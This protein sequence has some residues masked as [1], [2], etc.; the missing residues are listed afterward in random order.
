[1]RCSTY[2]SAVSRL[3]RKSRGGAQPHGV[4]KDSIIPALTRRGYL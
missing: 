4:V 3:W 1:M 2:T